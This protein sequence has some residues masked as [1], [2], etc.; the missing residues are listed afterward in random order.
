[1]WGLHRFLVLTDLPQLVLRLWPRCRATCCSFNQTRPDVCFLKP[2]HSLCSTQ[3]DK[4]G[5]QSLS[6]NAEPSSN[7][8]LCQQ[9]HHEKLRRVK[10]KV[11]YE[12]Y[13]SGFVCRAFVIYIILQFKWK[14]TSTIQFAFAFAH[15]TRTCRRFSS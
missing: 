4:H 12:A 10:V 11:F 5:S 8:W 3:V 14:P 6:F 13:R 1:M 7:K 9:T 2:S 15:I